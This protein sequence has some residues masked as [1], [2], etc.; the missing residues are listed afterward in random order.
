VSGPPPKVS[1]CIPAFNSERWV[2]RTLRSVLGQ[3]YS[4]FEV[5]IVDDASTDSTL[6][7]LRAFQGD[8]RVR[9]YVNERNLGPVRNWNR[10]LDL[11]RGR[12]LKFLHSDDLLYRDCL[13]TMVDVLEGN[14]RIGLVFSRRDIEL[15]DPTDPSGLGFK[16]KFHE[17]D[18]NLGE[19]ARVNHGRTLFVRWMQGGFA[20][21]WVGEPTSVMMRRDCLRRVGTF[22][23]RS[24]QRPDMDLWLR[25]MFYFD[26][27]F[28]PRPLARYVVRPGSLTDANASTGVAWVDDL[29][30]FDGLLTYEE[31]RKSFPELRSLRRKVLL[32][33][34]RHA[35]RCLATGRWE[36][37]AAA[38]EY[39]ALRLRRGRLERSM[40]YGELHDEEPSPAASAPP[41]AAGATSSSQSSP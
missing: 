20:S 32:K 18:R 31:I 26:V 15:A 11:A 21:N 1:V 34:A 37:V 3:T 9:L 27:G 24:H 5:V 35:L 16:A 13:A 28:V 2:A 38:R 29:W 36:R 22:S 7:E 6:A 14:E 25:T 4:D 39:L 30:L 23:L 19:L 10:T 12:Y 17:G 41:G 33:S 40:L 8:P